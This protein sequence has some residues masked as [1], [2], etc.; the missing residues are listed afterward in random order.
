MDKPTTVPRRPLVPGPGHPSQGGIAAKAVAL[1]EETA[2]ARMNIGAPPIETPDDRHLRGIEQ[3][4]ESPRAFMPFQGVGNLAKGIAGVM[5][6]VGTIQKTGFNKFHNYAYATLQDLL[7]AL[8]PLMGKHG[9]V[10]I[11]NEMERA[12]LEGGRVQVTYEFSIFHT[13]GESWPEKPRFTGMAIGKDSKGNWDDKAIN[14]CHSAARKYFLL[15][16]FQVPSGDFDDA[17]EG[18]QARPQAEARVNRTVPGPSSGQA[19]KPAEKLEGPRK[20]VLG[21]GAGADGWAKA[22]IDGIKTAKTENDLRAWDELNAPVLQKLSEQFNEVYQLLEQVVME[23]IL[24]VAP[25]AAMPDPIIDAQEAMNWV[26]QH[27]IDATTYEQAETFWNKAV[28]P[29]ERKFDPADWELLMNEWRRAEIRLN[30]DVAEESVEGS[31]S[32]HLPEGT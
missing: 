14:K 15:S 29:H 28:A 31:T 19:S 6:E 21:Q 24:E 30:S 22:Y 2:R 10:V 12:A 11:Q 8:C 5:S 23:R 27:L 16:L 26:A 7:F 13:S 25:L 17:D 18:Q 32:D 3:V 1:R 4:R 9:V 20:I